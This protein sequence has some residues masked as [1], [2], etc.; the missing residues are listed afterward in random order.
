MRLCSGLL[1]LTLTAAVAGGAGAAG[2]I[3]MLAAQAQ[4]EKLTRL[5]SESITGQGGNPPTQD[6]IDDQYRSC[7]Y[8]K[9]SRYPAQQTRKNKL[10]ISGSAR[11]GLVYRK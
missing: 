11:I 6:K 5:L 7:I 8:A 3:T 10:T 2:K 4:C 1:A 9:S